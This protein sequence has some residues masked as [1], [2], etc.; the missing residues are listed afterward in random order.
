MN[1]PN[2]TLPPEG[3]TPVSTSSNYWVVKEPGAIVAGK[4][5]ARNARTGGAGFYYEIELTLP[6]T[7]TT[8]SGESKENITVDAGTIVKLDEASALTPLGSS[9][10]CHVWIHFVEKIGL[11]N[12]N[13]FWKCDVFKKEI[14]E[15][16]IPF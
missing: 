15:N 1:T 14:A 10:P 16:A 7:V 5:L 12:G 2:R 8:S 6:C 11:K 3:F 13:S 4:V 9:I